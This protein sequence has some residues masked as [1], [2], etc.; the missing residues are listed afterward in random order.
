MQFKFAK[1]NVVNPKDKMNNKDL[2]KKIKQIIYSV[3]YEK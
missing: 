1:I 2:E 3:A